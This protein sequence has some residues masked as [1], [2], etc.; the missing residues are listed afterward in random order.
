MSRVLGNSF[1]R[2]LRGKEAVRPPDH[3]DVI[4]DMNVN[5]EIDVL[6]LKISNVQELSKDEY[7]NNKKCFSG[8]NKTMLKLFDLKPFWIDS[9]YTDKMG[10]IKSRKISSLNLNE[11]KTRLTFLKDHHELWRDLLSSNTLEKIKQRL[12]EL[13]T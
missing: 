2:F 9:K 4:T 3:L 8:V 13:K 10:I 12:N 1:A 5:N 11:M 7:L 6:I